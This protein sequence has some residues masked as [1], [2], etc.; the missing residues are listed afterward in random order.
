MGPILH[1]SILLVCCS[2]LKHMLVPQHIYPSIPLFPTGSLQLVS[3]FRDSPKPLSLMVQIRRCREVEA[4]VRSGELI[5]IELYCVQNNKSQIVQKHDFHDHHKSTT[6][7]SRQLFPESQ[8][9][10]SSSTS[11]TH[12]HCQSILLSY[13]QYANSNSLLMEVSKHLSYSFQIGRAHV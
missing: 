4:N 12:G 1:P 7:I 9:Q 8:D 2:L 6:E 5:G 10:K 3:I 11:K 13:N